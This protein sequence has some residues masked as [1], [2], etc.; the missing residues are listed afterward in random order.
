MGATMARFYLA[1]RR[2]VRE[3]SGQDVQTRFLLV[4]RSDMAEVQNVLNAEGLGAELVAHATAHAGVPSAIKWA[5]AA[6]AFRAPTVSSRAGSPVKIGEQLACGIP[7]VANV[8]GD[9]ADLFRGSSA[10]VLLREFNQE[11]LES[12]AS[13]IVAV[14]GNPRVCEEARALAVRWFDLDAAIDA[15]E[16]LYAVATGSEVERVDVGWPRT[17]PS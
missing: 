5:E 14:A 4:T 17:H 7:V 10:A 13:R 6:L 16:Q 11:A 3:V 15:Y 9:I 12:A 1:W 2:A 8:F